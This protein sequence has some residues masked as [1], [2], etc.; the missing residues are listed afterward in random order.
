MRAPRLSGSPQSFQDAITATFLE[1]FHQREKREKREKR[2]DSEIKQTKTK[3]TKR[4][5][6]RRRKNE[7][8]GK[9]EEYLDWK[10]NDKVSV[11]LDYN[12]LGYY[13]T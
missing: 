1:L 3:T 7:R 13:I 8:E 12:K 5:R 4:R 6:I 9:G 10:Q 2:K 11:V